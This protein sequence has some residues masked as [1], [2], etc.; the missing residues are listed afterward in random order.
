[1]DDTH[2]CKL[3]SISCD[4]PLS[5]HVRREILVQVLLYVVLPLNLKI[6]NELQY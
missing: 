2:T 5:S 4:N 3:T 1:M 6:P